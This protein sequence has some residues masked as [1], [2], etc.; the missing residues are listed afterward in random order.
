[1]VEKVTLEKYEKMKKS[2]R[3]AFSSLFSF[4]FPHSFVCSA[5]PPTLELTLVRT[6]Y[7]L[8]SRRQEKSFRTVSL[9]LE[10]GGKSFSWK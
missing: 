6:V 9:F 10:G 3:H 4:F 5:V 7:V 8:C 1:M 2:I